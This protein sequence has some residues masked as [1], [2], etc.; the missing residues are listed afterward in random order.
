MNV[1]VATLGTERW[2]ERLKWPY[3]K[4][5]S[6]SP[7]LAFATTETQTALFRKTFKNFSFYT[8]MNAGYFCSLFH[9]DYVFTTRFCRHM[10]PRDM[11]LSSLLLLQMITNDATSELDEQIRQ[12]HSEVAIA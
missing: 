11:P 12:R 5:F 3:L 7:K 8:I 1:P 2:M 9:P 4:N 10:V 6:L